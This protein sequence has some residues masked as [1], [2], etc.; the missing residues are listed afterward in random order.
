[1]LSYFGFLIIPF[2]SRELNRLFNPAI[3]E[4]YCLTLFNYIG[5]TSQLIETESDERTSGSLFAVLSI[6]NE[7]GDT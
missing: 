6:V 3:S 1:M 2:I 4:G 7:D 5:D